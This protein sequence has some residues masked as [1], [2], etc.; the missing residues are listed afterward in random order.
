MSY[1]PQT[2]RT[3]AKLVDALPLGAVLAMP[4]AQLRVEYGKVAGLLDIDDRLGGLDDDGRDALEL[5]I[6]L[7]H[8]RWGSG[9][10]FRRTLLEALGCVAQEL[11]DRAVAA[12]DAE[13]IRLVPEAESE[14][15]RDHVIGTVPHTQL[16]MHPS[17]M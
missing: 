1:N 4:I 3:L 11:A 7:Q 5:L 2:T 14:V 9:T 17:Q 15:D 12:F 8:Q 6:A 13:A 16:R 10:D